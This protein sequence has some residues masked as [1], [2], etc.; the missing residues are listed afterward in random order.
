MKSTTT[1]TNQLK[2]DLK[3]RCIPTGINRL[4]QAIEGYQLPSFSIIGGASGSFKS[5]FAWTKAVNLSLCNQS[6]AFISSENSDNNIAREL[7]AIRG[8]ILTDSLVCPSG[9]EISIMKLQNFDF[10]VLCHPRMKAE[11]A[12][13]CVEYA[14]RAGAGVIIFDSLNDI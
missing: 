5:R 6:V 14:A 3:Y 13:L 2:N 7:S 4:D 12:I 11:D 1:N 8:G 10:H 9:K